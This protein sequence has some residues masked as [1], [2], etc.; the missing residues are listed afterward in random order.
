MVCSRRRTRKAMGAPMVEERPSVGGLGREDSGRE[1]EA[2]FICQR[3]REWLPR[4]FT[5]LIECSPPLRTTRQLPAELSSVARTCAPAPA[6]DNIKSAAI[7]QNSRSVMALIR[8]TLPAVVPDPFRPARP[9]VHPAI[10]RVYFP[11]I[12]F[13]TIPCSLP[14]SI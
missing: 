9:P 12:T 13:S 8:C 7:W 2:P 3:Y 6:A 11:P 4:F 5:K 1:D 14:V 10:A